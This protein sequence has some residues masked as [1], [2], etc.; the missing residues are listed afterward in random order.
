MI[1]LIDLGNSRLKW[2]TWHAGVLGTSRAFLHDSRLRTE[3]L[4]AEWKELS[5]PERVVISSVMDSDAAALLEVWIA[6][7]WKSDIEFLSSV[8]QARGVTNGYKN[9]QQLGV[10]RWAAMVA[11]FNLNKRAC[12]VVDCGTATTLDVLD[13]SG[14]HQGGLIIPG[15]GM[16]MQSLASK[17]MQIALPVSSRKPSGLGRSTD[18][19]ITLGVVESLVALVEETWRK[20]G[21][22]S[23]QGMDIIVTGG[24]ASKFLE[25]TELTCRH[26]PDLVI[27]GIALLDGIRIEQKQI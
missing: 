14:C 21:S 11:A 9:P 19:A 3:Q 4:E 5:A 7:R 16:M 27:Q 6:K 12:L 25:A 22:T 23:A 15:L 13:E 10:D 17:T 26:V 1:L 2:A 24:D 20:W 8:R 18:E